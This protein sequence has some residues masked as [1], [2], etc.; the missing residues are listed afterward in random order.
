M[1][2]PSEDRSIGPPIGEGMATGHH[3]MLIGSTSM[4]TTILSMVSRPVFCE[5]TAIAICGL[6]NRLLTLGASL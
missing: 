3:V 4:W 6:C 1:A 2:K 5:G